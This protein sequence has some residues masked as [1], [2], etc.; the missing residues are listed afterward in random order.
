LIYAGEHLRHIGIA[1][2]I[3]E[4]PATLKF[5]PLPP[6]MRDVPRWWG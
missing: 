3:V 6:A 4:A 5:A 2:S 1:V